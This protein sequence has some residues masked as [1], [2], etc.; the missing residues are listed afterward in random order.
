MGSDRG[1]AFGLGWRVAL[2]VG[3]V[4]LF[5]EA[6]AT[7]DLA[8]ARIV[9]AL[10]LLGAVYVL[11][12]HVSRTNR[13][14]ARFVE[15]LRYGDF[16]QGF[17]GHY[18]VGV[19]LEQATRRLRDERAR[20]ADEARIQTALADEAPAALLTIDREGRVTLANKASRKLFSRL[21]GTRVEDFAGYGA[22]LVALL[23]ATR[24]ATRRLIPIRVD[25]IVQ[26]AMVS[27]TEVVRI[28]EPMTIVTVQPIQHELS[29]VELAAQ[30]DLVR[31]LT[32]EI[33]NS[34]TPV[35]SLAESAAGIVARIDK[36]GDPDIADARA[37]IETLARRAAGI[38]HFV[39]TYRAFSRAPVV[40]ARRFA[41]GPWARELGQLFSASEQGGGVAFDLA[42][43]PDELIIDADPD[44]LAQVILNLLKNGAEA[45]A[46]IRPDPRVSLGIGLLPGSRTRIAVS[47]NG[48]GIAPD[49]ADEIFLP[50][51]TTKANGTGVGLSL[52]RR[53][54]VAHGG[55]IAL[56]ARDGEGAC[57]ELIV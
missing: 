32:H 43:A 47:D 3:A 53:I 4:V 18:R 37:A 20:F 45:A 49:L 40:D 56:A 29:A 21:A 8:A 35:V 54:M 46:A 38:M 19:A 39:E 28:A 31:V 9:A 48:P 10:L 42:I 52:A 25:G 15:G 57:F 1:F 34:M 24:T 13:D 26:R 23:G 11:W 41:A 33:M 51:F 50:F 2:L 36:G 27:R 44:L 7:P 14:L 55:S 5:G 16:N 17:G 12:R 6:C 22:E 30:A